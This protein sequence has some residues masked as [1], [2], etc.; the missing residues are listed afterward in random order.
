MRLAENYSICT[1]EA[2][3]FEI[4]LQS[5]DDTAIK[6]AE[7]NLEASIMLGEAAE[8]YDLNVDE[9]SVQA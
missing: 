9:L 6:A 8:K 1:D 2:R 4:A 5:G 7:E 3:E